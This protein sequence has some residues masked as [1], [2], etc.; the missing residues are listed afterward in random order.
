ME[1]FAKRIM[2][3]WRCTTRNF[4]RGGLLKKD[5]SIKIS[6]K[7]PGNVAL[8]GNILEFFFLDTFKITC[9]LENL[10]PKWTQSGPFFQK[11]GQ[12]FRFSK[13]VGEAFALPPSWAPVSVTEYASISL[14]RPKFPWKCLNELFYARTPNMP[15]IL[16]K[17]EF[18]IWHGCICNC[19]TEFR[20]SDYGSIPLN[21]AWICFNIPQYAWA[22]LNIAECPWKC[23]NKQFWLCQ[24][25][26]YA[27]I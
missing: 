9:W 4:S 26:H 18:W 24:G 8:Q 13:T 12:F 19:Y 3:E 17:A 7:T 27:A 15:Q 16:N 21:N 6:W 11:S 2:P 22:W 5:T 20:M 1:R 10:T 14:E 25:S 23:Q